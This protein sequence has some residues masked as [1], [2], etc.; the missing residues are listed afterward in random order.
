MLDRFDRRIDIDPPTT[1]ERKDIFEVYLRKLS[2]ARDP[3]AYSAQ[4]AARTPG[5]SGELG[6]GCVL[7]GGCG[8]M[9]WVD[10]PGGVDVR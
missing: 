10:L 9:M 8:V 6:G 4:L 2:L 7:D 3:A 1:S 5:M